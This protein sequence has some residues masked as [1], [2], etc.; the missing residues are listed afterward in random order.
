MDK[1][2]VEVPA[3]VNLIVM[4]SDRSWTCKPFL[5]AGEETAL[6]RL[7]F[8]NY[9]FCMNRPERTIP[10]WFFTFEDFAADI[11]A[12]MDCVVQPINRAVVAALRSV[13]KRMQ[14][15]EAEG[16]ILEVAV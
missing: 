3:T 7:A 9:L 12:A 13:H 8:T 11:E 2:I 4:A 6:V 5:A 1:K 16:R 15:A 14:V 10:E